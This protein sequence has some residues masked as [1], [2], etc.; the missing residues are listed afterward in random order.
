MKEAAVFAENMERIWNDGVRGIVRSVNIIVGPAW[1][2]HAKCRQSWSRNMRI[3]EEPDE[4]ESNLEHTEISIAKDA[5]RSEHDPTAKYE[6]VL[7]SILQ[8]IKFDRTW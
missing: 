6:V 4:Q 2:M 3:R 8:Y 1:P 7:S 5:K